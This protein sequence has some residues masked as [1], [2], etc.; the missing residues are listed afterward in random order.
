MNTLDLCNLWDGLIG[1]KLKSR[2][3][4]I[5]LS[6]GEMIGRWIHWARRH[7]DCCGTSA[8]IL[9][10]HHDQT[11]KESTCTVL[12][13]EQMLYCLPTETATTTWAA[14]SF[15]QQNHVAILGR[16]H[17]HRLRTEDQWNSKITCSQMK[18]HVSL[19]S[20]SWSLSCM[21]LWCGKQG[22]LINARL[23]KRRPWWGLK[24]GEVHMQRAQGGSGAREMEGGA[25]WRVWGR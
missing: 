14:P 13:Y 23:Q 2:S 12:I 10:S 25:P 3:S 20:Y 24:Y 17:V 7:Q 18:N 5:Y 16:A 11:S 19:S 4:W 21:S 1:L 15:S 9:H 8:C 22:R 6:P